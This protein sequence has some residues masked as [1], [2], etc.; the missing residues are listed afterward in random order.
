MEASE[1]EKFYSELRIAGLELKTN[2]VYLTQ[3]KIRG[4]DLSLL[5]SDEFAKFPISSPYLN[6]LQRLILPTS[7]AGFPS[8]LSLLRSLTHLKIGRMNITSLPETFFQ[9]TNLE[10]LDLSNNYLTQLSP[11]I[12]NLTKLKV[13][14]VGGNLLT[15][16]PNELFDLPDLHCLALGTN[17]FTTLPSSIGKATRLRS[18]YLYNNL[19]R[20]LPSEI[21][22]LT[23]LKFLSMAEN[24]FG[25]LPSAVLA[26]TQLDD[27][28]L[29]LDLIK[30]PAQYLW[31]EM[32][33]QH[34]CSINPK[35]HSYRCYHFDIFP[36]KIADN[37]S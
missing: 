35:S 25:K 21:E 32:L 2:Q 27:L 12:A 13:L 3:N 15:T 10:V 22:E 17:K 7:S 1:G 30:T 6:H 28:R 34:G 11:R 36:S 37:T 18:L 31:I 5:Q 14:N 29:S 19:L 20:E 33:K 24:P 23:H 26:L 16:L 9:L 8:E 4:L